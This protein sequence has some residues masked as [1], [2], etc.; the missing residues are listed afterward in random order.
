MNYCRYMD[1]MRYYYICDMYY[2]IKYG[3]ILNIYKATEI[4]IN[5]MK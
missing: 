3:I 5:N 1:A 4:R 2:Y